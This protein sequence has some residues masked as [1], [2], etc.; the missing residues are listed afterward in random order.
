[1][2]ERLS[3]FH[4]RR[5]AQALVVCLSAF[6]RNVVVQWRRGKKENFYFVYTQ[7]RESWNSSSGFYC[8]IFCDIGDS[9]FMNLNLCFNFYVFG[10]FHIKFSI[11]VFQQS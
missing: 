1:M 10:I 2:V 6:E 7:L 11:E 4:K 5:Q 9:K 8:A 3:F